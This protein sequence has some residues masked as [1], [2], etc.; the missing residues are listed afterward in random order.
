M[1]HLLRYVQTLDM[2]NAHIKF[3]M[4]AISCYEEMDARI[5]CKKIIFS[6]ALLTLLSQA[7]MLHLCLY[8]KHAASCYLLAVTELFFSP[9]II[10][11]TLG[12]D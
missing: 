2:V 7:H 8:D 3:E 9:P 5:K 1:P 11:I 10:P 4:S 6:V 12:A